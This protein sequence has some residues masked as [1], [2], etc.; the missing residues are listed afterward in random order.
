MKKEK[1]I[2]RE[3]DFNRLRDLVKKN[4]GK[5][6]I[7]SSDDDNLNRKVIE[8]L[9]VDTVLINLS[10]RKDYSKQRN[11]GLNEIIVR[12]LAK[13]K[14][15]VGIN[16]DELVI[17]K[18]KLKVVSRLRQN[19]KLCSRKRVQMQFILGKEKRSL[20][21]LKSFGLV[22]GMPTWMTKNLKI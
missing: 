16:F 8:K 6:I 4:K 18:D 14:I 19:I 3:K 10:G 11:S 9:Q 17:S 12:L 1:I 22:L 20:I 2:L 21:L 7:F 5:E 13:N 15:Q